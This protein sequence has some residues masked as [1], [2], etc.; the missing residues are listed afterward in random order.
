MK[1]ESCT[2]G[3]CGGEAMSRVLV[4][5]LEPLK[6]SMQAALRVLLGEAQLL[7]QRPNWYF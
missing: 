7:M 3:L 1:P 6:L 5:P 2:R 4:L